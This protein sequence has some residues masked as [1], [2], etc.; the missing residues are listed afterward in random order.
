MYSDDDMCICRNINTNVFY[1]IVVFFYV[2]KYWQYFLL[3][4]IANTFTNTF[5]DTFANTITSH[6]N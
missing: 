4:S 5:T 1:I 6:V 3:E 2:I